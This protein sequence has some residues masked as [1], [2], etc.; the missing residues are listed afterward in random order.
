[1]GKVLRSHNLLGKI[2]RSVRD[3][4]FDK[5][6]TNQQKTLFT[7]EA[8]RSES[9]WQK[10]DAGK[11][12]PNDNLN[13]P[14]D[15]PSQRNSTAFATPNT[16]VLNQQQGDED[17]Q[18]DTASVILA[19][20]VTGDL[21][22]SEEE[23]EK[24]E[25]RR[26]NL[27]IRLHSRYYEAA[28]RVYFS[29]MVLDS[30]V[31]AGAPCPVC[32]LNHNNNLVKCQVF[33]KMKI[34]ERQ[35]VISR[36]KTNCCRRCLLFSFDPQQHPIVDNK[37]P[38][39]IKL[40]LKCKHPA[41]KDDPL[42][43]SPLLCYNAQRAEGGGGHGHAARGRGQPW[44]G[45]GRGGRGGA[46]SRGRGGGRGGGRGQFRR[47]TRKSRISGSEKSYRVTADENSQ[48]ED[49]DCYD[50]TCKIHPVN[51]IQGVSYKVHNKTNT[52]FNEMDISCASSC[53]LVS[54]KR[55]L[56]GLCLYDS[57]SSL[58]FVRETT[59]KQLGLQSDSVW[60]GFLSTLT[61][62]NDQKF[63]IYVV[64]IRGED[65]MVYKV[66]C[67]GVEDIGSKEQ[68]HTELLTALCKVA[69][70][71]KTA[72]DQSA[73]PLSLL[74]GTNAF[75]LFPKTV[76]PP[77][78]EKLSKKHPNLKLFYSKL[79]QQLF[80]AGQ[81]GSQWVKSLRDEPKGQSFMISARGVIT[82]SFRRL[83]DKHRKIEDVE[84]D[85]HEHDDQTDTL[86]TQGHTSSMSLRSDHYAAPNTCMNSGEASE[87]DNQIHFRAFIR[88]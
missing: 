10:F 23:E 56:A 32:S 69:G 13:L 27:F 60:N 49:R 21:E 53:T 15:E 59:A 18:R 83:S 80:F 35:R 42:T 11:L 82:S 1:M 25:G 24:M 57:G 67:L 19:P 74:L 78:H 40:D 62:K 12:A 51:F 37:C 88:K 54:E 7:V 20:K 6:F 43:H 26:R 34:S 63:N 17:N 73:G 36:M 31:Q 87:A 9:Y 29:E 71:C 14:E 68:M 44:R 46:N 39:Q 50:D 61:V 65:G 66:S 38:L 58:S 52:D 70:I 84:S 5:L 8:V 33:A 85:E 22:V 47:Q 41:C 28:R 55:D 86:S 64:K 72:M 81:C 30:K 77:G 79:S 16:S 75:R 3:R 2:D 48:E 76:K 4:L 45:R